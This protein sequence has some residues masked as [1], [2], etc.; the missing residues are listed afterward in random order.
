M[1][2]AHN[3]NQ[4]PFFSSENISYQYVNNYNQSAKLYYLTWTFR[5]ANSLVSSLWTWVK[6]NPLISQ[7]L[8]RLC[9]ARFP[10][11]QR[12]LLYIKAQTSR[13]DKWSVSCD[14]SV[15]PNFPVLTSAVRRISLQSIDWRVGILVFQS[16]NADLC[17]SAHWNRFH[18]EHQERFVCQVVGCPYTTT[19]KT[20]LSRHQK[21]KHAA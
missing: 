7:I 14:G 6:I 18:A 13:I 3:P 20:D 9:L 4:T 12:K 19:Y 10:N 21:S 8:G 1:T 5:T 15:P 2:P 16:N 11:S 17:S